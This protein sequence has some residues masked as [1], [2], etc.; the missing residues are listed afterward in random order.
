VREITQ[1]RVDAI[2]AEGFAMTVHAQVENPNPIAAELTDIRFAARMG[3]YPL[4]SGA[5]ADPVRAEASSVFPLRA[6]MRVAF[7]NLPPDLPAR[8]A[9]GQLPLTV[10]AEF[11]AA[12]RIGRFG[13]RLRADDRVQIGEALRVVIAGGLRGPTVRITEITRVGLALTGVRVQVRV[14]LHN[15][16]PFPLRIRRGDIA[17]MLGRLQVGTTRIT[18]GFDMPA[19]A[20]V[21]R[22]LTIAVSHRDMLRTVRAVSTGQVQPRA[23]GTLWIEPIAGIERIPF[24]VHTELATVL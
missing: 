20:R 14:G 16:F 17:L 9:A 12:T 2:D 23:V 6:A 22:E 18:Q 15:A 24:D 10:L 13:M 3:E 19:R 11:T 5:V 1:V 8:V 21:S 7:A 4:G